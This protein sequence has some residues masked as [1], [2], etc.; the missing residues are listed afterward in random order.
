MAEL[1]PSLSPTRRP[2]N[3]ASAAAAAKAE[4]KMKFRGVRRRPWGRFTA[5]IRDPWKKTRVW[6]GTFDSADDAARA[7]DAAARSFRGANAKTNFPLPPASEL[8]ASSTVESS[9]SGNR[10]GPTRYADPDKLLRRMR[11]A[12]DD[13]RSDCDS[14]STVMDEEI[15]CGV[16]SGYQSSSS[17]KIVLPF[18][19]NLPAPV[20]ETDDVFVVFPTLPLF[21][22]NKEHSL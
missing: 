7:Y 15:G 4:E 11:P 21:C 3:P 22:N 19:L 18:D 16:V 8:P 12:V 2:R 14:S 1:L 13:C 9:S 17:G 20:D 5:E 6:L 10:A